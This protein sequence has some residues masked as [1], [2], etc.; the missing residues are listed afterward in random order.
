MG[1]EHRTDVSLPFAVHS[2]P[3]FSRTLRSQ[4]LG[5]FTVCSFVLSLCSCGSG[6]QDWCL[7]LSLCALTRCALSLSSHTLC[8]LFLCACA[9]VAVEHKTGVSR[10]ANISKLQAGYLFPEVRGTPTS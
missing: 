10:N 5:S 8:F 4:T 3:V 7:F 1:V 6:A 9:A 2:H